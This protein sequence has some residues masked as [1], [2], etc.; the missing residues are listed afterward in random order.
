MGSGQEIVSLHV[1]VRTQQQRGQT[2]RSTDRL[3]AQQRGIILVVGRR[4][5]HW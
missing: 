2:I 3:H 5:Q 1:D 4:R